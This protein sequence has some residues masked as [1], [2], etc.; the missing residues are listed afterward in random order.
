MSAQQTDRMPSLPQ[1]F[2]SFLRLG[3][4]AFGGP[5]MV[6]YIRKMAVAQK[7]WF[8]EASFRDGVAFCQMVPGATAMQ[9]TA[10][11]G[12]RLRGVTGAIASF[13]G[14]GLPAF[15]IMLVLSILYMR[16][17]SLPAVVSGFRG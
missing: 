16:I 17:Q 8:D 12:L 4:T 13:V 1:L 9:T 10:Y 11:V 5:A 3:A 6:A 2:L 15:S 14:F 7:K